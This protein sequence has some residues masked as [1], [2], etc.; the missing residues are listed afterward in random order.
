MLY[1]NQFIHYVEEIRNAFED[2]LKAVVADTF[3]KHAKLIFLYS[4]FSWVAI[5]SEISQL[6]FLSGTIDSSIFS[7]FKL[8][9]L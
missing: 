8:S 2:H 1:S 3:Q 7:M 4:A 9:F 5:V 6:P